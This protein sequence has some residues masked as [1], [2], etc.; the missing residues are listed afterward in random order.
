[1]VIY[2]YTYR[3]YIYLHVCTFIYIYV[4][5]YFYTEKC[6]D[7]IR[8]VAHMRGCAHIQEHVLHISH[9]HAHTSH[10]HAYTSTHIKRSH[11]E[12]CTHLSLTHTLTHYTQTNML[13]SPPDICT[14]LSLHTHTL[15]AYT[16]VTLASRYMHFFLCLTRTYRTYTN[17]HKHTH[18]ICSHPDL[19]TPL[20]LTH[21]LHTH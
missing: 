2:T 15:H 5:K 12:I 11:P 3:I 18:I 10:I 4:C 9:T 16:H 13:C 14:S 20:S 8:R 19:C 21:T 17:T 1:M 6:I 7:S